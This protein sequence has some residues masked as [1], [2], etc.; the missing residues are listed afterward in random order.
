MRSELKA[1]REEMKGTIAA[2]RAEAD[3]AAQAVADA[4]RSAQGLVELSLSAIKENVH[5]I[6]GELR[7][8]RSAHTELA[9]QHSGAV[10]RL[11]S[12]AASTKAE[13][14]RELEALAERV[15]R[16]EEQSGAMAAEMDQRIR[17]EHAGLMTWADEAR[18]ELGAL[19]RDADAAR[20]LG[21][22]A[23]RRC[24]KLEA[25]TRSLEEKQ[26]EAKA[27]GARHLSAIELLGDELEKGLTGSREANEQLGGRLDGLDQ[28]IQAAQSAHE[29]HVASAEAEHASLHDETRQLESSC[30]ALRDDQAASKA[31]IGRQAERL[32]GL[33]EEVAGTTREH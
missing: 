31:T 23:A 26:T 20:S 5:R 6:E 8:A 11:D 30:A 1:I 25:A 29:Q 27:E 19:R 12:S 33:E 10:A 14:A 32:R 17:R 15:R 2:A 9:T 22:D 21:E 18:D 4:T 28:R 13:A 7:E 24:S 3:Q 16:N